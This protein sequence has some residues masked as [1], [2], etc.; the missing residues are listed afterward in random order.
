MY[1]F[2][3]DVSISKKELKIMV[4]DLSREFTFTTGGDRPTSSEGWF[5]PTDVFVDALA[6]DDIITGTT[7]TGSG[8]SGIGLNSR[9]TLNTSSGNDRIEGRSFGSGYGINN[10]GTINTGISSGT[11]VDN[12]TILGIGGV[13]RIGIY[14]IGT[15][16]TGIGSDVI[17]G[18][19]GIYNNGR[20]DT[21]D[22]D[23]FITGSTNTSGVDGIGN[24]R[25]I[26]NTGTGNDTI[27]GRGRYYG[28]TN[29]GTINTDADNDSIIG[30][31]S[32]VTAGI[33]N[34]GGTINTGT[35]NDNITGT[36]TETA[37][38][39]GII[40]TGT[41]NTGADND[42]I[43]GYAAGSSSSGIYNNSSRTINTDSG[44][45]AIT[46]SAVIYGINNLGTIDT[47]GSSSMVP[48]PITDDDIITGAATASGSG[49]S[50]ITN[51]GI[52]ITGI[53]SDQIVGTGGIHG[54]LTSGSINT[55]AGNDRIMG[56]GLTY[57]IYN[58]GIINTSNIIGP[59]VDD[60]T[61]TGTARGA[62]IAYGIYNGV[63]YT[64][65]TR[66]GND[67][68][69]GSASGASGI[70][71]Y[72]DGTIDTGSDR[73]VV[74]ALIGGFAGSGITNLGAGDDTLKG[75]GR[76]TFQGGIGQDTLVF[77]PGTYTITDGVGAGNYVING[78]MNVSGFELF[79]PGAD[80][81]S[82]SAA[83]AAGSVRF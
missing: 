27:R 80:I 78:I 47:T 12:D 45:D 7:P 66:I 68:I 5:V 29:D 60:D 70:G 64:I 51:S 69:T 4:R 37:G 23:D 39:H 32:G 43:Y 13:G 26:I 76:G 8:I 19:G 59:T 40:N 74:D 72:N 16:L 75:F 63:G 31:G 3:H 38:I 1:V 48:W 34:N 46:G 44:N 22:G 58:N 6:G 25:G 79:G 36:A 62:G 2:Y 83:V 20:I 9:S 71:I 33:N 73:D 49:S 52:I 55:G 53:G 82:F 56:N 50:G 65:N 11:S 61:I 30:E 28:I 14:N 81:T 15:I 10:S 41:I 35:G 77:N 17:L 24:N 54:I 67:I 57:G 18:D 42:T 21:G